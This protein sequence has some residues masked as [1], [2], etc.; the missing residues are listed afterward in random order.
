MW[1]TIRTSLLLVPAFHS[2]QYLVVVWRYQ[3]NYEAQNA[4]TAPKPSLPLLRHILGRPVVS[5]ALSGVMLGF[6]GFYLIPIVLEATVSYDKA[7]FGPTLF[8]FFSW[9]F[10]NIHHYFIDS[11]IW[12]RE[13]PDARRYLLS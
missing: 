10:I 1:S 7:L 13:N 5:F 11:V 12:R 4:D 6:A 9:I 3:L 8:M 2:L